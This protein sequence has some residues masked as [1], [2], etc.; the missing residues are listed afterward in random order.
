MKK[1]AIIGVVIVGIPLVVIA[2]L[3][4]MFTASGQSN[5][6]SIN[7]I[8]NCNLIAMAA[9]SPGKI[10]LV[11]PATTPHSS[12]QDYLPIPGAGQADPVSFFTSLIAITTPYQQALISKCYDTWAKQTA[13]GGQPCGFKGYPGQCTFWA[14]LNWNNPAMATLT[15]NANQFYNDAPAQDRSPVA[16]VPAIGD[17]VVWNSGGAYSSVGHVAIVVAVG[18]GKFIVSEMNWSTPW[19]IQYRVVSENRNSPDYAT[20]EGFLIP[21]ASP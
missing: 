20:T 3:L 14:L 13:Y 1:I 19:T 15:G 8:G 18:S 6:T 11:Y 17:I 16:A 7:Q 4:F 21:T 10:C 12:E 9:W 2:G 5:T